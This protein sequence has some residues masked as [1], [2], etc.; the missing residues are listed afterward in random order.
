MAARITPASD[1]TEWYQADWDIM[2]Y[3]SDDIRRWME[4]RKRQ[5]IGATRSRNILERGADEFARL[6]YPSSLIKKLIKDAQDGK[7]ITGRLGPG[8]E[9][10]EGLITEWANKH[11]ESLKDTVADEF[12][13]SGISLNHLVQDVRIDRKANSLDECAIG[14]FD[15]NLEIACAIQRLDMVVVSLGWRGAEDNPRY[16]KRIEFVGVVTNKQT[17]CSGGSASKTQIT[18]NDERILLGDK[19]ANTVFERMKDSEFLLDLIQQKMPG[20]VIGDSLEHSK[21]IIYNTSLLQTAKDKAS[22][23]GYVVFTDLKGP[24][25]GEG[26][27]EEGDQAVVKF[28]PWELLDATEY[29]VIWSPTKP[30][31]VG[32]VLDCQ[33]SETWKEETDEGQAGGE[34]DPENPS[35][36]ASPPETD[37]EQEVATEGTGIPAG[38]GNDPNVSESMFQTEITNENRK[39]LEESYDITLSLTLRG[40]PSIQVGD[41][42]NF[43]GINDTLAGRWRV[44]SHTLSMGTKPFTSQLNLFRTDEM[45]YLLIQDIVEKHVKAFNFTINNYKDLGK[46]KQVT[47]NENAG[48]RLE[49]Y[50]P[51]MV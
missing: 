37:N 5:A 43:K 36:S 6:G 2:I 11:K 8:K 49:N 28:I 48:R 32:M 40:E 41:V 29:P 45:K 50:Y 16:K 35:T 14:F 26:G 47:T 51:R 24:E 7:D 21:H 1:Y 44:R 23:N 46:A 13:K 33:Y 30:D 4:T 27:E 10:E 19:K 31:E 42:I 22:A 17:Q 12:K 3:H 25:G 20:V 38:D 18:C 34:E 15:P 9:A 39:K